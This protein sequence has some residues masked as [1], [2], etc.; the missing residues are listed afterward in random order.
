M[1]DAF[2]EGEKVGW[3]DPWL[4]S[5]DL[6]YHNVRQ[7]EGLY[8]ELIREKQLQ[9]FV[10]DDEIRHAIRQP[11]RDTRAYFRGRCIEKF[12][13]QMSSVQWDAIAFGENEHEAVVELL[14]VFDDEDVRRYNTAIDNAPDVETL[15]RNLKLTRR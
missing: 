8:A 11:P 7:E 3:D 5:L 15:L 10:T 13:K 12:A 9:R 14:N 1:L 4:Q 6:E 2:V